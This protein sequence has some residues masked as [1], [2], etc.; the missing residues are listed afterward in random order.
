MP[1]RISFFK[2]EVNF[3][4]SNKAGIT[5]WIE[6]IIKKERKKPGTLNF[7]FC[8]DPF[9]LDINKQYLKHNYFTDI[10]TFNFNEGKVVNGEVYISIDRVKENAQTLDVIFR[11]ELNRVI[12]HGILHLLGYSDKTDAQKKIMRKKE[13]TC[14]ALLR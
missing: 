6:S 3:R 14:L 9:L 13:D 10:I 12:I 11:E 8:S 7:I 4:F 2:S 5:R 1:S